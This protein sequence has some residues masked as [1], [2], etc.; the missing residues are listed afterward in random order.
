MSRLMIFKKIYDVKK[1]DRMY[2]DNDTIWS[3]N[4]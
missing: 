2:W 4:T 3:N 1:G